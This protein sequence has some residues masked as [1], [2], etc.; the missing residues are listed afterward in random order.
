MEN[1]KA[2]VITNISDGKNSI[3]MKTPMVSIIIPVYN[4]ERY[5]EQC[6]D[7]LLIQTYQDFEIICVDD[8]STDASLEIM[9]KYGNKYKKFRIL[10]QKNQYAGVAR[11]RGL[12]IAQ[13]KYLLF[14]DSD[15]FF[16][17]EMLEQIITQAEQD[18][19]DILI[20]DVFQFDNVSRQVIETT[21]RPLKKRLFGEGVKSAVEIADIIFEFATSAPWNKLF[22]ADFIRRN[23]LWFQPIQ[24][25]NDLYFVFGAF[26]CAKRIGVLDRKLIYY[27]DNNADSLQGSGFRTPTVFAEAL[28]ALKELLEKRKLL[29]IFGDSF[30]NMAI[31]VSVYNLNNMKTRDSYQRLF[32]ALRDEI[33]PRLHLGSGLVEPQA[34]RAIGANEG[35]IIYG[36][37]TLA[38]A[39]ANFLLYQCGYTKDKIS[40]AVSNS[41]NNLMQINGIA[42]REFRE[43]PFI[44]QNSLVLIA[45]SDCRI[46]EEIEK[47]VRQ[48]GF[49]NTVRIGFH[50]FAAL[51]RKM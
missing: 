10:N 1:E 16:Y 2:D 27:R 33:F 43:I 21:W 17:P 31:S 34:E 30:R 26:A 51:V 47:D 22:L 48:R 20:F 35:L 8:G 24:R 4:E 28:Y 9:E 32:C 37:G 40:I 15:D 13:G 14:L 11:N 50:E 7:S 44:Q 12:E 41:R 19:T 29:D 3:I 42:V 46:Q 45:V 38:I 25:S 5:I 39:I 23:D 18:K 49:G 36:A 6:L